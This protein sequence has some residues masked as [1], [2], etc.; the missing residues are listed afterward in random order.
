[1]EPVKH[2]NA[3]DISPKDILDKVSQHPHGTVPPGSTLVCAT[4]DLNVSYALTL[5]VTAFAPDQSATVI[6]HHIIHTSIPSTL[7][8]TEYSQQVYGALSQAAQYL[9]SLHIPIQAWGIDAGGRNWDTV[10]RFARS[11]MSICNI[12]ACAMAGRASHVI[13]LNPR[14]RLRDPINSTV[15]CGDAKERIQTGTGYKYMFFDA[16]IYKLKF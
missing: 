2:S 5:V 14:N 1:M 16:D 4:T 13:T 3:L 15:L 6:D 12:P 10:C 7:N 11:S 9:Q 8:D